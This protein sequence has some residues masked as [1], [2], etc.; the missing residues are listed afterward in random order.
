MHNHL[1]IRISPKKAILFKEQIKKDA[2]FFA[3]NSIIDYS[4]LIGVH[5]TKMQSQDL[6]N[7]EFKKLSE[8]STS[9]KK[10]QLNQEVFFFK[11]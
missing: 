9:I 6:G 10:F 8:F 2:E 5:N 3:R 4:L 7:S 11:K 1:K